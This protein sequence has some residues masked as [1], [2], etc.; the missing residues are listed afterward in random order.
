MSCTG[1]LSRNISLTEKNPLS[2]VLFF[3]VMQSFMCHSTWRR[4]TNVTTIKGISK[5]LS[6]YLKSIILSAY[7]H[8]KSHRNSESK[9]NFQPSRERYTHTSISP[10][11]LPHLRKWLSLKH[12]SLT[13]CYRRGELT[14][15]SHTLLTSSPSAVA[16]GLPSS[17]LP[18]PPSIGFNIGTSG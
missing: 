18:S 6:Q 13:S 14:S 9:K 5:L 1:A 11:P 17:L 7:S 12:R 16:A 10:K 3:A 8:H 2:P 4:S 15:A